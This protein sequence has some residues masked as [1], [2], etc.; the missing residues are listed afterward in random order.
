MTLH[1][2]G[3][4]SLRVSTENGLFQQW[5]ALRNSR[6]KR[7]RLGSFLVEGTTAI[8]Q[9]ISHGWEIDAFLHPE[10]VNLSSWA[11]AHLHRGVA[12]QIVAI[13]ATLLSRLCE[14]REGTELLAVARIGTTE[15]D[16]LV[17]GPE[18]WLL[19]VLDRPKSAGNVGTIIRSAKCFGA[20]GLVVTGHAADPFDPSCVRASVGT[21]FS[22]PLV[23]LPSHQPLLD[24][25]AAQKRRTE[26]SVVATGHRA[27]RYLHEVELTGNVAFLLGN[28][29]L[30]LSR[31]YQEA[32]DAFARLPTDPAQSS[33]NVASA[34]AAALYEARRQRCLPS[35]ATPPPPSVA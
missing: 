32:C 35:P 1:E 8:D 12:A 17:L 6:S 25:L 15:L 5:L 26:V 20:Q 27:P 30:G 22:L 23:Q 10:G 18:P 33:L 19:V 9:A 3:P 14:R 13:S 28:E 31:S 4:R 29:T 21:L 7:H 34:A 2:T 16:D 11:Q 24:W